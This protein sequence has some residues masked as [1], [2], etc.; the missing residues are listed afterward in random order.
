[1]DGDH[2]LA[3][4][5]TG[6]DESGD[7]S[8][9]VDNVEMPP[10]VK[11]MALTMDNLFKII[12]EVKKADWAASDFVTDLETRDLALAFL[13]VVDLVLEVGDGDGVV[14]LTDLKIGE[15]AEV[16]ALFWGER[17]KGISTTP[18]PKNLAKWIMWAFHL[19]RL[20]ARIPTSNIRAMK[21]SER[22]GFKNEGRVRHYMKRKGKWDDVFLISILRGEVGL[23]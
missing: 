7:T 22:V 14:F 9:R 12:E 2:N 4:V 10:G 16:S 6:V 15:R 19:E 23:T 13:K 8:G 11:P 3:A 5:D 1:M 17:K 20:E 21:A 18:L